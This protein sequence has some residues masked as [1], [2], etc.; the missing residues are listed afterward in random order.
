M[1]S[2]NC[3]PERNGARPNPDIHLALVYATTIAPTTLDAE[4]LTSYPSGRRLQE[5]GRREL[6]VNRPVLPCPR[7]ERRDCMR[8]IAIGPTGVHL[9][10]REVGSGR[11][12]PSLGGWGSEAGVSDLSLGSKERGPGNS[13]R[14]KRNLARRGTQTTTSCGAEGERSLECSSTGGVRLPVYLKRRKHATSSSLLFPNNFSFLGLHLSAHRLLPVLILL[15]SISVLPLP[16]PH[17]LSSTCLELNLITTHSLLFL[18]LLIIS[19]S[20]SSGVIGLRNSFGRSSS[21]L[22][23]SVYSMYLPHSPTGRCISR[24]ACPRHY[25]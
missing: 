23:S 8:S 1:T 7:V 16:L 13:R 11:R 14:S 19:C 21:S 18:L 4:R 3:P 9:P 15:P 12:S 10:L 25:S 17:I 5:V 20:C 2:K 22:P 24:Q 6:G